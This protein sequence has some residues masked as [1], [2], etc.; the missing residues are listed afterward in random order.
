VNES[1]EKFCNQAKNYPFD[2]LSK[3]ECFGQ[4]ISK[5]VQWNSIGILTD[6]GNKNTIILLIGNHNLVAAFRCCL[7]ADDNTKAILDLADREKSITHRCFQGNCITTDNLVSLGTIENLWSKVS[8]Q[9]AELNSKEVGSLF[10]SIE[11]GRVKSGRGNNFSSLTK[12]IVLRDSYGRCMFTGCGERLNYDGLTGTNGNYS[13][14]AHNVASSEKGPR[15]ISELSQKLSDD[16]NNV[17]LLCDKHHRLVDKVAASDYS[18]EFLSKMRREFCDVSNGLLDGLIYEPM[19]VYAVLWPVN[20]QTVSP[21]T[22]LQISGCLNIIKARMYGQIN[23]LSDNEGFLRQSPS[24]FL[25][26]M[27]QIVETTSDKIIQQAQSNG[28]KAAL[29]AFG[30]MTALIGLGAMLGNKNSI[31]PMLRYRDGGQWVWPADSARGE[32]YTVEGLD[33]LVSGDDFV[34][35]VVLTA[36]PESLINTA[37][38]IFN[39]SNAQE[40]IFRA[41]KEVMGN[42]ALPHPEDGLKITAELQ[43]VLHILKD[44]YKAKQIHLLVCASNAACVFIGQAFDLH[45]P[46]TLIYDFSGDLMKPQLLIRSEDS[47]TT[48]EV[49]A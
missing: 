34:I 3:I 7:S 45:H 10:E 38:E 2:S 1:T 20:S 12:Q 18:A 24:I 49:I 39:S 48:L 35:R 11:T 31:I 41:K 40:I 21:P 46:N 25:S 27:K 28:Y 5:F 8:E 15:G 47:K 6:E 42:G 44:K 14:L 30:P 19:P 33:N 36:E 22:N 32:F 26:S 29:F 37:I 23:M 13:Y 43:K 16:P 4:N 9:S 17:L